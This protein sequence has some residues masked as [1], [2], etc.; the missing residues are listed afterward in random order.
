MTNQRKSVEE[1]DYEIKLAKCKEFLTIKELMLI[2][3]LSKSSIWR[4][5]RKGTLQPRQ[6]VKRG[7]I[8]F[9]KSEIE[10][11]MSVRRSDNG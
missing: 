1:H 7:K 10:N 9:H 11:F 4:F 2:S 6:L 8:L 5:I 3:S